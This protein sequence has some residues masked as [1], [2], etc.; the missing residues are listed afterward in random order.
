M[1]END[2]LT[3]LY[4]GG[5]VIINR[6][7][8]EL[9]LQ[10]ISSIVKDGFKQGLQSGFVGGVPSAIDIF[11]TDADYEKAKGIIKAIIE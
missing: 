5:D 3:K 8:T 2:K 4:T 10:G 9:E 1:N 11:V 7:K 6:I